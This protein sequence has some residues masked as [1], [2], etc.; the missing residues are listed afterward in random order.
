MNKDKHLN[1]SSIFQNDD[2]DDDEDKD[3]DSSEKTTGSADKHVTFAR[4]TGDQFVGR[5][6]LLSKVTEVMRNV[7][8]VNV[9]KNLIGIVGKSGFGKTAFMV[10]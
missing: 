6:T 9:G 7:S 5:K 4:E 10:Q 8:S 3:I 1:C 2:D